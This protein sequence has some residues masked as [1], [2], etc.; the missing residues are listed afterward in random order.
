MIFGLVHASYSWPEWQ[1]VGQNKSY[2]KMVSTWVDSQFL[3]PPER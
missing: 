2:V 3:L 1:A